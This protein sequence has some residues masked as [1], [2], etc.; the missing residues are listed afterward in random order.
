MSNEYKFKINLTVKCKH[1]SSLDTNNNNDS[2]SKG[3]TSKKK[4]KGINIRM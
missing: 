1:Y 4:T 3:T 2:A